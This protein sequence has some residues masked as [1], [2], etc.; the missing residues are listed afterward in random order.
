MD[1]GYGLCIVGAPPRMD[2]GGTNDGGVA[3]GGGSGDAGVGTDSGAPA[4]ADNGG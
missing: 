2:A 1:L 4:D 3:D